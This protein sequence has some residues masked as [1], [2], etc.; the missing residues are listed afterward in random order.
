M[1]MHSLKGQSLFSDNSPCSEEAAV[2][3]NLATERIQLRYGGGPKDG[4]TKRDRHDTH[5]QVHES[6][7]RVITESG[8]FEFYEAFLELHS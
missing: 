3:N 5:K 4:R 8:L 1:H 7:M 2:G 6:A